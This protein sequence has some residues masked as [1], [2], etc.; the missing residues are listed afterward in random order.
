MP[1]KKTPRKPKQSARMTPT[2]RQK[3]PS[4]QEKMPSQ[5]QKTISK[6]RNLST[7]EPEESEA[8]K[9]TSS[10]RSEQPPQKRRQ[11]AP[12]QREKPPSQW[13]TFLSESSNLQVDESKESEEAE[14]TLSG[15]SKVAPRTTPA[16]PQKTPSQREMRPSQRQN[17]LPQSSELP[18]DDLTES[19]EDEQAPAKRAKKAGKT[20]PAKREKTLLQR[21]K[22]P[23]QSSKQAANGS[24]EAVG[25]KVPKAPSKADE[26][27]Q[28]LRF[29]TSRARSFYAEHIRSLIR[30]YCLHGI[31][32]GDA[33]SLI[34][35]ILFTDPTCAKHFAQFQGEWNHRHEREGQHAEWWS[36]FR[37]FLRDCFDKTRAA[38]NAIAAEAPPRIGDG[39]GD[40]LPPIR[41]CVVD[42]SRPVGGGSSE[43][44][45]TPFGKGKTPAGKDKGKEKVVEHTEKEKQT[46]PKGK[47]FPLPA[48]LMP[49]PITGAGKGFTNHLHVT[50]SSGR[51][52]SSM[53]LPFV[54]VIVDP[55]RG[56][57]S[58]RNGVHNFY[59]AFGP[60]VTRHLTS[61]PERTIRSL[62]DAVSRHCDGREPRALYGCL[63][64][65]RDSAVGI[66]DV[67]GDINAYH[68][69][70]ARHSGGT[71]NFPAKDTE[72]LWSDRTVSTFFAMSTY[73]PL[74]VLVILR[75]NPA[76]GRRDTPPRGPQ[77]I[78]PTTG[79]VI[80]APELP[81][82]TVMAAQSKKDIL[83]AI[84][85]LDA[86]MR[87][88]EDE[89][90]QLAEVARN[91]GYGNDFCFPHEAIY[92]PG[93]SKEGHRS[94]K[95]RK[96]NTDNGD[97]EEEN[98]DEEE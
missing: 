16:K 98:K 48:K 36:S 97:G 62:F 55:D 69:A 75:R 32:K 58:S 85:R 60:A 78:F 30:L 33:T 1:P 21:E 28:S 86:R 6:S 15:R 39:D 38:V 42:G 34:H 76:T 77:V 68:E 82:I 12:S 89:L 70:L 91:C 14:Q 50:S 88:L 63:L 22:T 94:R 26:W 40:I 56:V 3:T 54:A 67:Q 37:A 53:P 45:K 79:N 24:E 18:A 29:G 4:Q 11:I 10:K 65:P 20:I 35:D 90:R 66:A 31:K 5:R 2:K 19:G 7:D 87:I 41:P 71:Y 8:A 84:E 74:W 57:Y 43:S 96:G 92:R 95:R 64:Q 25:P 93:L 9:H 61:L 73:S 51:S 13:Q 72:L 17:T 46:E 49:P 52:S 23:S 59:D 27:K 81:P 83:L 44:A 47:W 80:V